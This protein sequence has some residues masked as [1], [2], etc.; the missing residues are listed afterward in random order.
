MSRARGLEL[1]N[2]L[3]AYLRRWWVNAESAG[4]GRNG[5]DVLGTPGVWWENKTSGARLRPREFVQQAADSAGPGEL[6]VV[7]YWQPGTGAKS[8]HDAIAM[9]PLPWLMGLLELCE[10]APPPASKLAL[11]PASL[12]SPTSP[13][14]PTVAPAAT[15]TDAPSSTSASSPPST[16]RLIKGDPS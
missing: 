2:A 14:P 4:S 10:L 1:Q 11:T 12:S 15:A 8:P 13:P 3:A 9:L 7:V 16:L 6:P 5:R